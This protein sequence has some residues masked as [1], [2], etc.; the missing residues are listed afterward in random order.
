VSL[1]GLSVRLSAGVAYMS[2]RRVGTELR[3]CN[4]HRPRGGSMN[5]PAR[6]ITYCAYA[7]SL[8]VTEV[9]RA[10]QSMREGEKFV[11]A[12]AERKGAKVEL[13]VIKTSIGF[14]YIYNFHQT[15][16]TIFT[17]EMAG[18]YNHDHFDKALDKYYELVQ[19]Y[20]L[21]PL[22]VTVPSFFRL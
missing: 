1:I 17:N 3:I 19:K 21:T 22:P 11:V 6:L 20:Q 13:K 15:K 7:F 5:I 16:F 8:T 10:L 2:V 12:H 9:Q 18:M 14:Q 4:A